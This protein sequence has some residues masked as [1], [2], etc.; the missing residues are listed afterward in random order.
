MKWRIVAEK[1]CGGGHGTWT[2]DVYV[3]THYWLR[4]VH[5]ANFVAISFVIDCW[6]RCGAV[7]CRARSKLW[8]S[9]GFPFACFALAI[10][11]LCT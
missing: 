2:W 9:A 1:L 4:W 8:P 5:R 6:Y 10:N 7:R 3:S 11:F